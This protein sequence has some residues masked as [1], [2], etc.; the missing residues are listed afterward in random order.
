M[1]ECN[2]TTCEYWA[3]PNNCKKCENTCKYFG[4]GGCKLEMERCYKIDDC[5]YKQLLAEQAKNKELEYEANMWNEQT[6]IQKDVAD[7]WFNACEILQ[8]KNKKLVEA[9]ELIMNND[10]EPSFE[11]YTATQALLANEVNKC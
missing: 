9:L 3:T 1:E 11:N 6:N 5:Y 7:N 8:S 4:F 10:D 2:V